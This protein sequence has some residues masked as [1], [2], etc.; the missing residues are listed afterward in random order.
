VD[1]AMQVFMQRWPIEDFPPFAA[2]GACRPE[3]ISAQLLRHHRVCDGSP[4]RAW[5]GPALGWLPPLFG[6]RE[7]PDQGGAGLA[8]FESRAMGQE[9]RQKAKPQ[10]QTKMWSDVN[11]IV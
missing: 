1:L 6:G 7:K 11:D 8:S 4:V 10:T 3:Q 9:C 5:L 2:R